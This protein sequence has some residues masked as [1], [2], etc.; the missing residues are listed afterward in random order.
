MK[1]LIRLLATVRTLNSRLYSRSK[2]WSGV[3]WSGMER[4]EDNHVFNHR[5]V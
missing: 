4:S 5:T 3:E 2:N 1:D